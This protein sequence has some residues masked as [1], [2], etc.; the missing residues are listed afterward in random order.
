MTIP[1][2]NPKTN[3]GRSAHPHLSGSRLLSN[4]EETFE[5]ELHP[6]VCHCR[7]E[8]HGTLF[9]DEDA[10]HVQRFHE[11]GGARSDNKIEVTKMSIHLGAF[12]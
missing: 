4:R 3:V 6:E 7:P 2:K 9:T 8:E 1:K 10:L 12:Y 5:E 11:A